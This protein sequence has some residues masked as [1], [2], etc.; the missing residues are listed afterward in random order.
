M[1]NNQGDP[2]G[3]IGH[4]SVIKEIGCG[5]YSKVYLGRDERDKK[6]VAIK[7]LNKDMDKDDIEAIT[8]EIKILK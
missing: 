4:Y 7:I 1:G 3:K 5:G 2:I 6:M 8:N